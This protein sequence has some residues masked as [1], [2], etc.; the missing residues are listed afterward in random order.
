[1]SETRSVRARRTTRVLWSLAVTSLVVLAAKV[2]VAD[3]YL[4]ES[5]SMRPTIYAGPDEPGDEAK[6]EWVL[7]LHDRD[8]ELSRFDLVVHQPEDGGNAVVKRVAGLPGERI[9]VSNGDILIDGR[10]LGPD[11][12]RPAPIPLFDDRMMGVAETFT[13][14][15]APDGP[16]SEA[17]GSW[18]LDARDVQ[19]GQDLGLMFLRDL[20]DGYL[21]PEYGRTLGAS[22]SVND[23]ILELEFRLD[24]EPE[25]RVRFRLVEEG[26]TFEAV[27]DDWRDGGCRVRLMK[28][29]EQSL[30][31]EARVP[32]I[33]GGW[34]RV[35]FSNVDNHLSFRLPDLHFGLSKE[36]EAN[37]PYK[38]AAAPGKLSIGPRVAFGG[39]GNRLSFRAIRVFRDMHY[40]ATGD[41]A[42]EEA[43]ALGPDEYFLLGDNSP[44]SSDSRHFGA[45][46]GKDIVGRPCA[47]VW[48]LRRS[49][50]LLGATP[51]SPRPGAPAASH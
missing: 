20:D 36:Y 37:E 8:P 17:D 31:M 43:L 48:P 26:D 34:N 1:M 30:L 11:A 40:T 15:R 35:R 45:V 50:W 42:V 14:K 23:G 2:F 32:E 49:R 22:R 10:R 33:G 7:V 39:E 4:V 18:S 47:I 38:G 46:H 29:N 9:L 24:G 5:R 44:E 12:P 3:A 25:G 16:W 28:W 41:I 13:F 51:P 21:D 27:L 19:T 6:R